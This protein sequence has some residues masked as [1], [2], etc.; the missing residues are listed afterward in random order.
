[1]ICTNCGSAK[2]FNGGGTV[3]TKQGKVGHTEIKTCDNCGKSIE[4]IDAEIEA[5]K[6]KEIEY[7]SMNSRPLPLLEKN[8]VTIGQLKQF[9][10]N[11]PDDGE[12]WVGNDN[13]E[14]NSCRALYVLNEN[15]I[16]LEIGE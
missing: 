12:V 14:S 16:I 10:S 15:D 13:D 4:F 2:F 6:P 1:M 7:N 8:C 11:L 3:G 5:D 9:L